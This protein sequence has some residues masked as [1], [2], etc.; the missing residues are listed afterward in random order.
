MLRLVLLNLLELLKLCVSCDCTRCSGS[1]W[2]SSCGRYLSYLGLLRLGGDFV[3]ILCGGEC[4]L[5]S[6]FLLSFPGILLFPPVCGFCFTRL[7]ETV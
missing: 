5:F 4:W 2:L 6:S 3:V 1:G 7:C